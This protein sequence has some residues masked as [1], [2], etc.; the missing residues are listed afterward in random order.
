MV[1]ILPCIAGHV[2]AD[3]VAVLLAEQSLLNDKNTLIVD[4]GTNAEILFGNREVVLSASE[5]N[6]SR[7]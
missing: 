2:G 5:P 7:V 1:H 6:R 4:I 3:N